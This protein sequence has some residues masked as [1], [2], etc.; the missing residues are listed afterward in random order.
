MKIERLGWFKNRYAVSD[1]STWDGRA[2]REPLSATID[3]RRYEFRPDGRKR[4][5][6]LADGVETASAARAGRDWVVKAEHA[7]YV[8]RR[9]S[10]W[11]SPLEVVRDGSAV[12][13]AKRAPR[14]GASVELPDEVPAPVQAFI[15]FVFLTLQSRAA[16]S[17][18]GASAAVAAGGST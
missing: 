8:L 14:R 13:V 6:L 18:G 3:G 10:R 5:V 11:R 1:G 17:S 2:F 7:T 15:G 9:Q 4:F 16:A 12:G